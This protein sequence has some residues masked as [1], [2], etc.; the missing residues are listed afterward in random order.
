MKNKRC[1]PK[2]YVYEFFQ[3]T[4]EAIRSQDTW[5]KWL[6]SEMEKGNFVWDSGNIWW[7]SNGT[8]VFVDYWVLRSPDGTLWVLSDSDFKRICVIVEI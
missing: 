8:P 5:P 4:L 2:C 1:A 3:M 7:A 6:Q